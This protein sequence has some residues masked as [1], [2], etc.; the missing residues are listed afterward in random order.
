MTL[1]ARGLSLVLRENVMTAGELHDALSDVRVGRALG[2]KEG[3]GEPICV[4]NTLNRGCEF[5]TPGEMS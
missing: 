4:D 3:G 5:E 2:V 1:G